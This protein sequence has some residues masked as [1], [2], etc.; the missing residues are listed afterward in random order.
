M[1][2]SPHGSHNSDLER[3]PLSNDLPRGSNDALLHGHK[4]S[5]PQRQTAQNNGSSDHQQGAEKSDP[6]LVRWSPDD[7]EHPRNWPSHRKWRM[8]SLA[9][10]M[11]LAVSIASSAYSSAQTGIEQE[12]GVSDVAAT[13]GIS[14]FL[15]GL[16]LG[17]VFLAPISEQFGRNQVYWVSF[18]SKAA[19]VEMLTRSVIA[20]HVFNL[21]PRS[22][23]LPSSNSQ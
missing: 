9:C 7:E 6:F 16:G 1:T 22:S 23:S 10:G 19:I 20:E 14:L 11:E 13:V 17:A 21:L 3:Q 15:L 4:T 2:N 12:F 18:V 5:K 8:V